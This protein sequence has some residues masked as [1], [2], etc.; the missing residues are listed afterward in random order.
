MSPLKTRQPTGRTILLVDDDTNYLEAMALLLPTKDLR[1]FACFRSKRTD[2][3]RRQLVD[4]GCNGVG[5]RM[6]TD[7]SDPMLQNQMPYDGKKL[8]RLP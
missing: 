1:C 2:G 4:G 6:L 8:F 3:F 7:N 5:F